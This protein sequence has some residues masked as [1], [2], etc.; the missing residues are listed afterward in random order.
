[1]KR[2]TYVIALLLS[3]LLCSNALAKNITVT[4]RGMTET[5]ATND[6][7]RS[8]IEN[9]VGVLVDSETIVANNVVLKDEIYTN[10]KGLINNYQVV[11]TQQNVD[12]WYVTINADV[13]MNYDSALMNELTKRGIVDN[14]LRNPKIA[15]MIPE[16]HLAYRIPDPA[17][18][19]AVINAFIAA[20]FDNMVDIS[21]DRMRYN[22]PFNLNADDLQALANSMQADILVVGEAFSE[23]VGDVGQFLPRGKRTGTLSCRARV[24]AKMYIARTGQIIAAD[25]KYGSAVDISEAVASKKALAVAGK[26]MGEYLSD[27]LLELAAGSRQ[28]VE[29]V[30]M[31]V[32]YEKL[33]AIQQALSTIKG[34]KN[35]DLGSYTDGKGIFTMR[36]GGSPQTLFA[37]IKETAECNVEL[38]S[39]SYNVLTIAA[40]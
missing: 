21:Q 39:S 17:G 33:T 8:A 18:E 27:K 3:V 13:D 14:L 30:V 1:M 20:G 24:E 5:E 28:R 6:A 11:S 36:Y 37:K 10:T 26:E 7:L 38:R 19:T 40:W 35:V 29:L 4:G 16:K 22:N 2:F 31:T 15:V 34:V 25:G 32:G 9:A 23:G 12:G